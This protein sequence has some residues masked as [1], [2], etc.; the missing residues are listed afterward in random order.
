M[1]MAIYSQGGFFMKKI[2]IFVL[3][4]MVLSMSATTLF[5]AD[6]KIGFVNDIEILQAF[7]K[8]QQAKADLNKAA[9]EKGKTA[10]AKFDKATTEQDKNNIVQTYQMEMR[11]EEDKLMKPVFE[12]LNATIGKVAKAK[13]I[14]VVFNKPI[15]LYGGIDLTQA[16]ILELK[17]NK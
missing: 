10:Q 2:L 6:D 15:V 11:N 17:R 14:T 4:A 16:V 1:I 7:S 3:V 13:G 5:A 9:S 12:E 8:F